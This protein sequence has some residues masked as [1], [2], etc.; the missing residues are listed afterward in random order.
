MNLI[1]WIAAGVLAAAFLAAGSMKLV[2]PKEKRAESGRG[3]TEGFS[4]GAVRAIGALEVL[5]AIG[6]IVLMLG[7]AVTHLR[8]NE[9]HMVLVNVVLIALA[10]SVAWGRFAAEPF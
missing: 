7:A 6:L 2:Q 9:T 8:R 3:W 4:P 5:A 10:A 1:L